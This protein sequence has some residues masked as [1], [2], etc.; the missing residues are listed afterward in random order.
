MRDARVVLE[1]WSCSCFIN[2]A[3]SDALRSH[4]GEAKTV[5][6]KQGVTSHSKCTA[7]KR[8]KCIAIDCNRE[9]VRKGIGRGPEDERE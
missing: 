8:L 4:T 3:E 9:A 1:Y 7:L 5:G 2:S 6:T